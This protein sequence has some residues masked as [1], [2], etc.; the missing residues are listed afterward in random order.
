MNKVFEKHF[1]ASRS[2]APRIT[3]TQE[4]EFVRE[5]LRLVRAGVMYAVADDRGG[6]ECFVV[7][8]EEHER[9]E[10]MKRKVR[11]PGYIKRD[12]VTCIDI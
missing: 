1:G 5:L 6:T 3:T 7:M 11:F 9:N 12:A 2:A 4:Q 8:V 10:A